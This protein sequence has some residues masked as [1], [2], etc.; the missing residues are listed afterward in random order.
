MQRRLSLAHLLTTS[1]LVLPLTLELVDWLNKP[2]DAYEYDQI[3]S[4]PAF[5]HT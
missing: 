5:A 3:G 2:F 1:Q 4:C